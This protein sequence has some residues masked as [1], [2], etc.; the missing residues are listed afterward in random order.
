MARWTNRS[1]SSGGRSRAACLAA[2]RIPIATA[3]ALRPGQSI[4]SRFKVT[5]YNARR[6]WLQ[7]W[8]PIAAEIPV[9]QGCFNVTSRLL[10]LAELLETRVASQR[11]R[12]L[13]RLVRR[14]RVPRAWCG[15]NLA[16]RER[17]RHCR[18]LRTVTTT[19]QASRRRS[20][21]DDSVICS[22]SF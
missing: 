12:W 13:H 16:P 17:S 22:G 5:K 14:R 8:R 15:R 19:D 21:A 1:R 10:F 4:S 7:V 9:N 3:A 6:S 2:G 11:G 20:A 18:R